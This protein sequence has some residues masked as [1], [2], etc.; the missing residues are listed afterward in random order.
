[1]PE[2]GLE[3]SLLDRC[4]AVNLSVNSS[5]VA[6]PKQACHTPIHSARKETWGQ[7]IWTVYYSRWKHKEDQHSVVTPCLLISLDDIKPGCHIKGNICGGS[8]YAIVDPAP[9]YSRAYSYTQ[10]RGRSVIWKVSCFTDIRKTDKKLL[11]GH[12]L[13]DKK[14]M[15][16]SLVTTANVTTW[17]PILVCSVEDHRTL[18]QYLGYTTC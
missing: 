5:T 8:L 11:R 7:S 2:Q 12:L 17:W 16:N 13:K 18:T 9:N 1:M 14:Q 15:R 6:A 3:S 4:Q 10:R